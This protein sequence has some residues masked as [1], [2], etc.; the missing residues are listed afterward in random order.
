MRLAR[1]LCA[2]LAVLL[3]FPAIVAAQ[4]D[5]EQTAPEQEDRTFLEEVTVT[6]TKREESLQ[7]V[8]I[9]VTAVSELQLER[10][11]VKDIRDLPLLASS[12]NMNSTQTESQ[13]STLR[14]RGV[15][16][17]GNNIGLESAVGVFLDGVYLSRP[18]VALGDQLDVEA[19]EVLR[20]PQG[21]LFGRNVS[22]G[23][24]NIRTKAPSLGDTNGFANLTAGDYGQQNVQAGV[25]G[26][27]SEN[28]G[29]RLSGAYRKQDGFVESTTDG[30]ESLNRDR[31]LFRGQLLFEFGDDSSLRV[32][33]DYS[34]ADENCCDA[35]VVLESGAAAAG[36]FIAAGLPAN[37]GVA[38]SGNQAVEDRISNGQRYDNPFEQ[39]GVSAE[40][41]LGMGANS[42]FTYLGSFRDFKAS[43]VQ[44]DFVGLQIYSVGDQGIETF[45]EIESTSHELRFDGSS[46][47]FRWLFGGY[48]SD[49]SIVEN[50][51][52]HLGSDYTRFTDAVLWNFAFAPAFGAF[53]FLAGIPMAT[54]GTFGDILASPN[55]AL[56]FQGGFDSNGSFAHNL[57]SQDGESYSIFTDNTWDITDNF[58]FNFGA[59]Y[60]D[61]TKDG[62]FDQINAF[63]PGC[64]AALGNAGALGA[65]TA[66]TP[67]AG[68][69]STIG[70]FSAV[71]ACFP[72]AAPA[73]GIAFL[74]AEFD[75]TF[76]DDE[77]IYTGRLVWGFGNSS[78]LYASYTHGFKSGGFNLDSTAAASGGDP[79]FRSELVDAVEIGLKTE[80]ANRRVRL[81]ATIFDYDIEDF[82]VLEF[83]GTQFVTFNVPKA[84]SEG[85][86]LELAARIGNTTT[87]NFGYTYADSAYPT[88]CDNGVTTA[89]VS[90]LC[91]AQFT[92]APENVATFGLDFDNFVSDKFIYFLSASARY[93]DDR[94]TST[95]PNLAFDI[96]ESNTKVN[97]R[98]GI[99]GYSG[100]WT[101]E[102]W[103]NNVTD[104]QT[105]NV[106][107]N[108][109]LRVG[110][111]AVFVEAPATFGGTLRLRF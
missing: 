75:S 54:G 10:A 43:S 51:G 103:G 7:D 109:P 21:T 63:N 17:T 87:L 101:F 8:P 78:S 77:L 61:E 104:E 90:S 96:Q 13:G 36:S 23:A 32:I 40:L 69:A 56:A 91:G 79:R 97:L 26:P 66:G 37:G 6:A 74:P 35:P 67:L 38:V 94:R 48:Y 99:G 20:G 82:Q 12:F 39:E 53:P 47:S 27:M 64:L 60:V 14:I 86:E 22:A 44:N 28:S 85:A 108:T 88:D 100:K 84:A 31:V 93:E 106:T 15:G 65:A 46:D 3:L 59:R 89:N 11:G 107:F 102:I 80:F 5:A 1:L 34:D 9:A 71:Y 45:D 81:N 29:Y 58:A 16:T 111:R 95:Q 24:L 62:K 30:A 50:V 110:S 19:I 83:T 42:S 49:E 105:K 72:F 70:N 92:N 73:L 76:E 18:G 33:G 52:F 2:A 41:N 4:D 68:A 25:S 57:Y 98:A 55:Q